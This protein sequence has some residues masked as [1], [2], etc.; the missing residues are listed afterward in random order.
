MGAFPFAN[1]DLA[2][3]VDPQ[4][5]DADMGTGQEVDGTDAVKPSPPPPAIN[6]SFNSHPTQTHA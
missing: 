1:E 3:G 5:A 6:P 2:G 4:D